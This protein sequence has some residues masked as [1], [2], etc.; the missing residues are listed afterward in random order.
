MGFDILSAEG[1]DRDRWSRLIA[2][3]PVSLRDVHF[4]PEYGLI[5]RDCYGFE[6]FLAVYQE[7]DA[8]VLQSYVRRPLRQL[9]FLADAA[10]AGRFSDIANPY[11]FGGPLSNASP[12]AGRALYARFAAAFEAWCE[13]EAIASEFTSLHPI[14]NAQQLALMEGK[15]SP[16]HEK[17]VYYIDLRLDEDQLWQKLRRGHRASINRARRNEVRVSKVEPNEANLAILNKLYADSMRRR[18]AAQRWR[19]PE[20]FFATTIRWLGDRGSSL[21]FGYRGARVASAYILIHG[22]ETVY[23]HFSGTDA[24]DG[25]LG[26]DTLMF[27]EM[28]LW[29]RSE[30]YARCF[31]GGGVTRREEDGL[32]QFKSGFASICAPLYTCFRVHN[33][34]AY[35]DLAARK[36]TFE[37]ATTGRESVSTFVPIYRR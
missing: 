5:Y 29:A 17:D 10:D 36:R 34:A 23:Y 32:R 24:E 33:G 25:R 28:A 6:P 37:L 9:P 22:F 35:D 13:Q 11:G 19:F 31:L 20:D 15:L 8:F 27:Y 16:T 21:F 30:G 14:L 18:G 4:L 7:G 1:P 26:V 12:K 3:L 2:A